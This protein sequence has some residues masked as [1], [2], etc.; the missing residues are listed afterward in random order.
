MK[1]LS[2]EHELSVV[3][4]IMATIESFNQSHGITASPRAIRDTLLV[5]AGLLHREA[6]R[7]EE[8]EA[9]PSDM[10]NSF[11]EVAKVC[12]ERALEASADLVCGIP[13]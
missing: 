10:Q 11:A 1:D 3:R 5:A 12:L 2:L 7:L 8:D 13:Q 9:D 4:D 6:I